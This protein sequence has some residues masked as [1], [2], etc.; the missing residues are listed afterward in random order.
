MTPIY[1]DYNATTPLDPA[2]VAKAVVD[3][4]ADGTI[5]KVDANDLCILVGVFIHWEAKDNKEIYD[6]NYRATKDAVARAIKGLPSL[7]T[8]LRE[9]DHAKHPFA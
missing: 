7:D 8:V 3:S 5:S 9:K 1:L 4:V 6:F 2:A